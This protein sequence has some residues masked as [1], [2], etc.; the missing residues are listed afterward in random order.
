MSEDAE[1]EGIRL[2]FEDEDNMEFCYV[3][4]ILIDSGLYKADRD[5]LFC[6]CFA[7]ESPVDPD[8][9]ENLESIYSQVAWPGMNRRLIFDLTNSILAEIVTLTW[10][11]RAGRVSSPG[12]RKLLIEEVWESLLKSTVYE[13][14]DSP[15]KG[16]EELTWRG[17]AADFDG[18]EGEI[19]RMLHDDLLEELVTEVS[20][21]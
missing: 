5:T 13:A 10:D 9:F 19:E 17:C 4:D 15:G 12:C 6:A 18:V 3:L 2:T 21:L 14:C 11:L 1:A 20:S 7:P 16:V 8:V